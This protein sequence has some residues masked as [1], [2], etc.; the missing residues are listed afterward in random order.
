[1]AKFLQDA[2]ESMTATGPISPQAREFSDLYK[3]ARI[4]G[5]P[6]TMIELE[7]VCHS[8]KDSL[9]IDNL[10][11]AQLVSLCK[12]MGVKAFGTDS[13]L[14]YQ[15]R[16]TLKSIYHDDVEI[17]REGVDALFPSEL[18]AA[19]RM[20][21][22]FFPGINTQAM[23]TELKH[24]LSLHLDKGIPSVLLI[25]SRAL[26]QNMSLFRLEEALKETILSLPDAV[27]NEAALHQQEI[28]GSGAVSF[29]HKLEVLEQQQE[30]IAEELAQ[31]VSEEAQLAHGQDSLTKEELRKIS[32][33]VSV[34]S[35]VNPVEREKLE[36]EELKADISDFK[37]VCA[38][39]WRLC[40]H[41]CLECGGT[42]E[43]DE[44]GTQGVKGSGNYW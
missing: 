41:T 40:A 34:M 21:G 29:K 33:A 12:Y 25:L 27:V 14:R 4:T 23:R 13:F 36:L 5:E 3:K 31:S 18:E 42:G 20:R 8:L 7:K 9:T 16:K 24:W 43:H 32:D 30:F 19:C 15:I 10:D 35:S 2:A 38:A 1:M 17:A 28:A 11:R 39:R 6:L 22:L 26:S 37:Q 44:R